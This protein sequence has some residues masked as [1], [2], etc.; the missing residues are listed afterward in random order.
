[1]YRIIA[2]Q[3]LRNIALKIALNLSMWIMYD[4]IDYLRCRWFF[5]CHFTDAETVFDGEN[6]GRQ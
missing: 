3:G 2:A 1:M 5:F 4:I 6:E